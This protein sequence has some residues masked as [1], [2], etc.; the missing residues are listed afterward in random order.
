MCNLRP[1]S[2]LRRSR[3]H[4]HAVVFHD[5]S[6]PINNQLSVTIP[7][8]IACA[9]RVMSFRVYLFHGFNKS[10]RHFFVILLQHHAVT[11]TPS[12]SPNSDQSN[13]PSAFHRMTQ[14]F[15]TYLMCSLCSLTLWRSRFESPWA[16]HKP[17]SMSPSWSSHFGVRSMKYG[18]C[19]SP[20]SI[21]YQLIL[22]E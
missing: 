19:S 15:G 18:S 22:T 17:H 7:C 10:L 16:G 5:A 8:Q 2:C 14:L 21:Q 9:I 4:L 1:Y 6:D 20:H 12:S 13:S 11:S 3:R